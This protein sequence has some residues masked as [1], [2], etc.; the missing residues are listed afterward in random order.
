MDRA[1]L[2]DWRENTTRMALTWNPKVERNREDLNKTTDGQWQRNWITSGRHGR[3]PRR[4][5]RSGS[6]GERMVEGLCLTRCKEDKVKSSV[7]IRLVSLMI[8]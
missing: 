6:G 4:A 5:Q 3:R 7:M 8:Q 2:E 1:Y